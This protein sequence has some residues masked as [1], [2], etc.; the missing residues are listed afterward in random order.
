MSQHNW[1]P[2][3]A[4]GRTEISYPLND[5]W[6]TAKYPQAFNATRTTGVFSANDNL[7]LLPAGGLKVRLASGL[8]WMRIDEFRGVVYAQTDKDGM[9]FDVPPPHGTLMRFDRMAIRFDYILNDVFAIYKVGQPSMGAPALQRDSEAYEIHLQ[10][11]VAAPGTLEIR[12]DMIRDLR[13]NE[14]VCGIMRDGVS[15]IPTQALYDEWW[16]WFSK[17]TAEANDF[18]AWMVAFRS[19]NEILLEEWLTDFK[20]RSEDGFVSW[21][22]EFQHMSITM[23]N[24]WYNP[25]RN[26]WVTDV[27][28]WF[29]ELKVIL[30]GD[31]AANLANRITQHETKTVAEHAVHGM[32]YENGA[33]MILTETGWV[34]VGGAQTGYTA[35]YFDFQLYT[36]LSFNHRQYTAYEFDNVIRTSSG[37]NIAASGVNVKP[38]EMDLGY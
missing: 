18:L 17:T 19:D 32:R 35:A 28:E 8:A 34:V 11:V 24:N 37:Q 6:Y 1:L 36:A 3:E 16:A 14:A 30:D 29:D 22:N 25:W 21:F 26:K 33:F 38:E 10:E 13:L 2:E 7:R 23:L 20:R 27:Q 4:E 9:T 15:Q 5:R 31:V 12:N